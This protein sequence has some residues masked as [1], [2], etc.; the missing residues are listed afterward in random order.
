MA[1]VSYL[2]RWYYWRSLTHDRNAVSPSLTAH[3]G[4]DCTIPGATREN[5]ALRLN[6]PR[7]KPVHRRNLAP[8]LGQ[9]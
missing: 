2:L 8:T 9:P 1:D 5:V 3:S 7:A 4:R 6:R